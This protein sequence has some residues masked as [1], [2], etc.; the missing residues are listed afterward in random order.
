[1]HSSE[2]KGRMQLLFVSLKNN[3]ML[4]KQGLERELE[5]QRSHQSKELP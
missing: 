3:L 2:D 5:N 1:M 4:S